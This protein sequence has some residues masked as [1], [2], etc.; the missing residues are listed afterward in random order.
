[1]YY[2]SKPLLAKSYGNGLEQQQTQYKLKLF[3]LFFCLS[4]SASM[5]FLCC[6]FPTIAYRLLWHTF[7]NNQSSNIFSISLWHKTLNTFPV[8]QDINCFFYPVPHPYWV[9]PHPF[10]LR[11]TLILRGM[12]SIGLGNIPLRF[13]TFSR[14]M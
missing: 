3:D 8:L 12:D 14:L 9:G 4:V 2:R 10:A 11:T 5:W 7:L 6:S 1:M 13:H